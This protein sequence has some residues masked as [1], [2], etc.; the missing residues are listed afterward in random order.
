M[1]V[2]VLRRRRR[3][4]RVPVCI[5]DCLAL[6]PPMLAPRHSTL[7]YLLMPCIP[8]NPTSNACV[9]SPVCCCSAA[10]QGSL[11]F[12][13]CVRQLPPS[14]ANG[15][16]VVASRQRQAKASPFGSTRP[17]LCRRGAGHACVAAFHTSPVIIAVHSYSASFV[18]RL[19][20]GLIS[21]K[22]VFFLLRPKHVCRTTAR[23]RTVLR[24]AFWTST[25]RHSTRQ[26]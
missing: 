5:R 12:A 13:H 16:A 26:P 14:G 4:L 11:S 17:S 15:V 22:L 18:P 24:Q 7:P 19:I 25:T 2:R 21:R 3:R 1:Y 9:A 20:A 10:E 6:L 8:H 23:P